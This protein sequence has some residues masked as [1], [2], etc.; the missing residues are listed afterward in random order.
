M[1]TQNKIE[2]MKNIW[3]KN[4]QKKKKRE[5]KASRRCKRMMDDGLDPPQ[6]KSYFS[7]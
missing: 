1:K 5:K 6:D 2:Y 4:T 7:F 3:K